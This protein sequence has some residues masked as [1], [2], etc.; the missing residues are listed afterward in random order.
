MKSKIKNVLVWSGI[1][2]IAALPV[3]LWILLGDGV[4]NV[5]RDYASFTHG[6]GVI[7]GL[8]GMTLFALTFVLSTRLNWVED[9]FSGLD[10]SYLA[11]GILGGLALIL[12][13]AHP[14]LLVLK[15]VPN[16][17]NLAANYLLP[18]SY[19]SINFGII[20]I[21]G[22]ILLIFI[23]LFVKMKYHHWKFSHEFLGLVFLFAVLH[24]F[25]V[26][27]N[28]SQGDIFLG[29]YVYAAIVSFIGLSA[30]SYS[31][32]I[33]GKS[34]K[35]R[36]YVVKSVKEVGDFFQ[37]V[38]SPKAKG[39]SYKAGQFVFV[40][41]YNKNLL[42]EFHPFSIVSKSG[43]GD[44]TIVAKKLG[45]YTKKLSHLREG[46]NVLIEGPY[47]RFDYKE[48][49]NSSQVWIAA[50]V[51]VTPFIGMAQDVLNDSSFKGSIDLF[52]TVREAHELLGDS[53]FKGVEEKSTMFKYHS[54]L[55]NKQGR[56]NEKVIF[57]KSGKFRDKEF[58]ICG[59]T[60][61]KESIMDS[62][63]KSGVKKE[64]IHEEAFDFK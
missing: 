9:L 58:F 56:L 45:D 18:S 41:F 23:T 24:V 64:K 1:F 2:L 43:E 57:E 31:L 42:K 11:H 28:I 44:I 59:P 30:F 25:L 32:F 6:F 35:V 14:I 40:R 60:K 62:L 48:Y 21:S 15:F 39:I 17:I 8:V 29:Y 26:R 54:W 38:M 16:Q 46:D 22:F 5:M 34:S 37:I 3:L 49:S 33:K 55:S 7:F 20:A 50:G 4:N 36:K 53:I 52:Y 12:I 47:G 63:I 27:G 19:W 51:G 61:F 10:K 13:M